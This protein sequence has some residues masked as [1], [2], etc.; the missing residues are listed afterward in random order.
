MEGRIQARRRRLASAIV[1]AACVLVMATVASSVARGAG[2]R[3]AG[4]SFGWSASGA[5]VMVL[6]PGP[7]SSGTTFS[8]FQPSVVRALNGSYLMYY[9]GY[10]GYRDHVLAA[11]SPDG[12]VWTKLGVDIFVDS[13]AGSPFVMAVG[14]AYRMWFVSITWGTG[15]LGYSDRICESNSTDGL[16]W[17]P[18]G[19]VVDLG[20]GFAWDAGSVSDPE[21][22]PV[23]GGGY[24]M[25]YTSTAANGSAAIAMATSA[26]LVTFTKWSGNPVLLPASSGSW[27]DYAV[28]NPSV[29]PGSPWAMFY[30]GRQQ[31]I[32]DQIGLATSQDGYHWTR[33]AAPFL[34]FDAPGTWDSGEIAGPAYLAGGPPRLYYSGGTNATFG[35]DIGFVNLTAPA[36][37]NTGA[38][39]GLSVPEIVA[40]VVF[41]GAG[42][43]AVVVTGLF[44]RSEYRRRLRQP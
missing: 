35:T 10:D 38:V 19:V 1:L 7:S 14:G 16:T 25:Y 23:P 43:A 12:I 30:Q 26:D 5:R 28:S 29:I 21:V 11:S 22:V 18:P 42:V 24:R 41:V 15:P 33:I 31:P 32:H 13:G 20:N 2:P 17:S 39:L 37:G 34:P 9:T 27:D 40:L 3:A 4:S 44:L 6:A 8:V 36:A